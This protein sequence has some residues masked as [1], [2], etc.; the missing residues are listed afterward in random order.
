VSAEGTSFGL[1]HWH[2]HKGS[3]YVHTDLMQGE[4][5]GPANE[6]WPRTTPVLVLDLA[7]AR[8]QIARALGEHVGSATEFC[9]ACDWNPTYEE[10]HSRD[11]RDLLREHQA[12]MIAAALGAPEEGEGRG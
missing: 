7:G 9:V 1:T 3:F 8:E 12:E 10:I 11:E 6:L 2:I 4:A 5:C